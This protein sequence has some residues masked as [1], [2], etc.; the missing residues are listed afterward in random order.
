MLMG[1]GDKDLVNKIHN[2]F[3]STFGNWK[4]MLAG[5]VLPGGGNF[6]P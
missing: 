4:L 6:D 5:G 1:R 3:T 2:L